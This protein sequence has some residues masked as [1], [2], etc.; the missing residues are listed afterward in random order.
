MKQHARMVTTSETPP[1]FY[2]S[3][4]DTR[5]RISPIFKK[6]HSFYAWFTAE[7]WYFPMK[8]PG[9]GVPTKDIPDAPQS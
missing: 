6:I 1:R 2:L 5:K 4:W 7:K 9:A 3:D 8:G